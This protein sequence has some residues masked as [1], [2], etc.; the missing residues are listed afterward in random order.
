MKKLKQ[1]TFVIVLLIELSLIIATCNFL[2]S[3]P[4]TPVLTALGIAILLVAE[5]VL[6]VF[7]FF[8][9]ILTLFAEIQL[10]DRNN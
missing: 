8:S 9:P 4:E 10:N 3:N 7:T 1:I 5:C 2:T 6:L